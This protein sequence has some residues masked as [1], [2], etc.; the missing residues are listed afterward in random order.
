MKPL[1]RAEKINLEQHCSKKWYHSQDRSILWVEGKGHIAQGHSFDGPLIR[2]E[3]FLDLEG[4][5][6][7]TGGVSHF[8]FISCEAY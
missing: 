7:I 4:S 2:N 1:E 3:N 5:S 6:Q 8:T